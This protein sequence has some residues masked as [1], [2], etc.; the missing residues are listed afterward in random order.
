MVGLIMNA[1]GAVAGLIGNSMK[2][3]EI[4]EKTL[5]YSPDINSVR[6]AGLYNTTVD[7]GM[8]EGDKTR[9]ITPKA[10]GLLQATSI[11]APTV[12]AIG[13]F[14]KAIEENKA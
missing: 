11:M 1:V 8:R 5:S 14:G 7:L 13:E 12:G 10:K 9:T 3:K 4:T 6:N 2:D